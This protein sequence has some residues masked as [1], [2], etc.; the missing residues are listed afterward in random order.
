MK[1]FWRKRNQQEA[2]LLCETFRQDGT[3]MIDWTNNI[4]FKKRVFEQKSCRWR[5]WWKKSS[6]CEKKTGDSSV[7]ESCISMKVSIES[8]IQEFKAVVLEKDELEFR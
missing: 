3:Q 8:L 5:S 7:Q 2:E 4:W 6:Q 1:D